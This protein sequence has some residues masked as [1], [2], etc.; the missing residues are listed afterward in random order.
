MLGRVVINNQM[1]LQ[2]SARCVEGVDALECN[3]WRRHSCSTED[4]RVNM[5]FKLPTSSSLQVM[6]MMGTHAHSRA[7][8]TVDPVSDL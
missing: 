4:V 2:L 8:M 1:K 3:W 5:D 7:P 6:A